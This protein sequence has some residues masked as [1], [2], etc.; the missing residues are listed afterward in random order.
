M[1]YDVFLLRRARKWPA[2]I[3]PPDEGRVRDVPRG[4]GDDPRP[5]GAVKLSGR[6]GYRVRVVDFRILYEIDDA[7]REVTVFD[8]GHRRDV[9]R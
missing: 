2:G 9:Y 5:S 3:F 8:I 6:N 1:T 7:A 4:L